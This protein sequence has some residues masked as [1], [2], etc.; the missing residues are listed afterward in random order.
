MTKTELLQKVFE[1]VKTRL[2]NRLENDQKMAKEASVH[3]DD[4]FSGYGHHAEEMLDLVIELELC[5]ECEVLLSNPDDRL[6]R[7]VCDEC[8][9]SMPPVL[10]SILR[11]GVVSG[12][13]AQAIVNNVVNNSRIQRQNDHS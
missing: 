3:R 4:Y 10:S 5:G 6:Y 9:K 8:G 1:E 2:V 11:M 13:P 7:F 12:P